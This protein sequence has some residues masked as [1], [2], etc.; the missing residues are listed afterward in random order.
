MPRRWPT[1][2]LWWPR[3]RPSLRPA[4]STTAP[5]RS[6]RL[7]WRRRKPLLA[8]AGEEAEVLGL[9]LLRDR[10]AVP[11]GDRAHLVLGHLGEREAEPAEQVRRQRGEHVA[12][13]LGGVD[14]GRE[15]RPSVVLDDPG[16]VAGQQARRAEPLA[17]GRASPRAALRRCRGCRGSA[18][19]L[20]RSRSTKRST[21]RRRKSA[22]RS[23]VKCGMSSECATARA[24][25]T[26]SGEQHALVPSVS[27]S[28]QSFTVIAMTSTPRSRS[29][30]AATAES[31]PPETATA[32]RSGDGHSPPS[33]AI[34][35]GVS[36]PTPSAVDGSSG[37]FEAAAALRARWRASVAS[38]A[39][40]R[41]DGLEAAEEGF[42]VVDRHRRRPRGRWRPR[43]F[44]RGPRWRRGWHRIPRCRR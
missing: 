29:R 33:L 10:E 27:G 6:T 5:S 32:T 12:L 8:L 26:A 34:E 22:S 41:L 39:A 36:G 37:R 38:W 28:A 23:R 14:A 3:W 25:S 17:P 40:W 19:G 1:V 20:R 31:T 7:P 43:W 24:P 21:T 35:V 44:R 30:R 2:K 11:G 15:Q 13:V 18:S 9:G 4:R 42:G 16:V